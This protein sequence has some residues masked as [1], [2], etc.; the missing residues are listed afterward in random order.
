MIEFISNQLMINIKKSPLFTQIQELINKYEN[1]FDVEKIKILANK[2]PGVSYIKE[3]QQI[4]NSLFDKFDLIRFGESTDYE[5]IK[6][7]KGLS[8][9]YDIDLLK[10]LL[11]DI[12]L[13]LFFEIE[14]K[15][16]EFSSEDI[17]TEIQ[18]R[19]SK[20]LTIP[21]HKQTK[22]TDLTERQKENRNKLEKTGVVFS[23][24]PRINIESLLFPYEFYNIYKLKNAIKSKLLE[25][26]NK[27]N[28]ETKNL[29]NIN[30]NQNIEFHFK[31]EF[32]NVN[33]L[34]VHNYF[35]SELVDKN[36]LSLETLEKYLLLSFEKKEIP[37]EKFIFKK[38]KTLKNIR[39][40]FYNYY[41]GVLKIHFLQKSLISTN[42]F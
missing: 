20:G 24:E 35:K 27:V 34:E 14:D 32:D 36:Y 41:R 22:E 30:D 4:E 21:Y 37:Q 28:S 8:N 15:E 5:I 11:K 26:T 3:P 19:N 33:Y 38:N 7:L 16:C 6:F 31:N 23:K 42:S 12:D 40:I 29:N 39:I 13:Y 18:N 9:D 10:S 1:I 2:T 17:E 25:V